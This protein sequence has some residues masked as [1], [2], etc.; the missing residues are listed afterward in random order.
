MVPRS[1]RNAFVLLVFLDVKKRMQRSFGSV[2]EL[3]LVF[4]GC[5]RVLTPYVGSTGIDWQ[6]D[7]QNEDWNTIAATLYSTIVGGAIARVVDGK[8]FDRLTAYGIIPPDY[9]RRSFLFSVQAGRNAAFWKL[10]GAELPFDTAV[11]LELDARATPTGRKVRRGLRDTR[12]VALLR[13][14]NEQREID[15]AG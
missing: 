13:S 2:T 5:L 9:S 6:D 12:F 4:G 3:M 8:G 11:F 15:G 1:R 14:A 10:E 7:K